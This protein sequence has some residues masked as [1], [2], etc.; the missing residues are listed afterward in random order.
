MT[1]LSMPLVVAVRLLFIRLYT[2]VHV[3]SVGN[4]VSML[5]CDDNAVLA[6]II[7][8]NAKT[9]N[10]FIEAYANICLISTTSSPRLANNVQHHHA[11]SS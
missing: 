9:Y 2:I 8:I 6:V 4:Y 5:K 7:M 11:R 1:G 3:P 10:R